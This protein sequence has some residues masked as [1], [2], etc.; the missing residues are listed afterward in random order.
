MQW[1]R[2]TDHKSQAIILEV[3]L[4]RTK[5]VWLTELKFENV[6][7]LMPTLFVPGSLRPVCNS[8]TRN[9]ELLFL[10]YFN[11]C[12]SENVT[13]LLFYCQSLCMS[14]MIEKVSMLWQYGY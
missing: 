4:M 9:M 8:H 11:S 5:G 3:Y 14:Y 12:W 7:I 13:Y 6:R 2:W 1:R 10:S